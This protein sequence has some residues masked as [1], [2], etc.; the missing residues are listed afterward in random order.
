MGKKRIRAPV[1]QSNPIFVN[2]LREVLGLGPIPG[3]VSDVDQTKSDLMLYHDAWGGWY[4][5]DGKVPH[6]GSSTPSGASPDLFSLGAVEFI[7]Q[8]RSDSPPD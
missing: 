5:R 7:R 4:T 2:A 1:P 6:V 3:T 8:A